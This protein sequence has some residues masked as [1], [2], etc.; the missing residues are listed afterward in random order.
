MTPTARGASPF[1][2]VVLYGVTEDRKP[3]SQH[4]LPRHS[5]TSQHG[6]LDVVEDPT[7]VV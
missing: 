1:D 5:S 6:E 7:D 2:E 4:T 3:M